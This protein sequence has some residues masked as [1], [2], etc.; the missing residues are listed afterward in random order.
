MV[1]DALETSTASTS[2]TD[3]VDALIKRVAEEHALDVEGLLHQPPK[4]EPSSWVRIVVGRHTHTV[5]K[6]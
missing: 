5:L 2:P 6:N 3:E 1:T 4:T